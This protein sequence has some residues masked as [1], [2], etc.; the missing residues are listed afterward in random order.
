MGRWPELQSVKHSVNVREE[1]ISIFLVE[2]RSTPA[3]GGRVKKRIKAQPLSPGS[4]Q[5]EKKHPY[6]TVDDPSD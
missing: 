6:P 3:L 1:H 4:L 2:N 5:Q